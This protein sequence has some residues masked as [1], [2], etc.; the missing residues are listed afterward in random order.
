MPIERSIGVATLDRAMPGTS[1]IA[2]KIRQLPDASRAGTYC[3][4]GRTEKRISSERKD[5]RRGGA[6]PQQ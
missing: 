2:A 1:H 4:P 3:F 6:G 5:Y